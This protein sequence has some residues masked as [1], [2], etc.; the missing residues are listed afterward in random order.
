LLDI[1]IEQSTGFTLYGQVVTNSTSVV[2][3]P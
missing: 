2:L 3:S 1:D